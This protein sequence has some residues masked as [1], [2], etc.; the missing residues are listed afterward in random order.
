MNKLSEL[1]DYELAL[2]LHT[3]VA[4]ARKQRELY[5]EHP[6]VV[7]SAVMDWMVEKFRQDFES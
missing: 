1:S 5:S 7:F 3:T 4:E 6:D 2:L